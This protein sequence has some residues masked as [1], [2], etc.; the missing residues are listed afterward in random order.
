MACVTSNRRPPASDSSL[1]SPWRPKD[2]SQ[3]LALTLSLSDW[4]PM[5]LLVRVDNSATFFSYGS[6]GPCST[7]CQLRSNS[8]SRV[9]EQSS[10]LG[11]SALVSKPKDVEPWNGKGGPGAFD[12]KD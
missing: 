5:E 12:S 11:L 7:S 9:R 6:L 1:H 8:F 2:Q 3:P 10:R 4:I